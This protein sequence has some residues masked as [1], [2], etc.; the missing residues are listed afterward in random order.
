MK[1]HNQKPTPLSAEAKS[2]IFMEKDNEELDDID[3]EN[4]DE[5]LSEY[6]PKLSYGY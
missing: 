2:L 6:R 5:E 1:K 4:S 3:E